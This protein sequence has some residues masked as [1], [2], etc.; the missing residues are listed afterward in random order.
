[1]CIGAIPDGR[2][3]SVSRSFLQMQAYTGETAIPPADRT[4]ERITL[5]MRI[6][7]W[8]WLLLL[9]YTRL[10]DGN[11][12][13]ILGAMALGTAGVVGVMAAIRSGFLGASWFAALDGLATLAL[14]A[15][16]W[17]AD[18]GEFIAGGYPMSW[19]FVAAYAWRMTGALGA[20]IAL[21]AWMGYLHVVM[22]FELTRTIGSIQFI[23]VAVIAGWT[24]DAIRQREALRLTAERERAAAETELS[25]QREAATRLEERTAIARELHDS[26][27]QTMKLISAAADD[28]SEVRYLARMQERNLRKTI[29]EYRSPHEDSLRARLLEARAE[30]EDKC[31]V[32]IEQVIRHD[33]E[34][35][36]RLFALVDAAK[37]AMTNAARHSGS[38]TIDLFAE[39]KP[40][41][42]QVNVRDRGNGFDPA[43]VDAGGITDSIVGR[44]REVGGYVDIDSRAGEGTDVSLFLPSR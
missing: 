23:V 40:G 28:P 25:A 12:T 5:M 41:G 32:H 7:G 16:G 19:L 20:S 36:P 38:P 27:L 13:I 22:G 15:A 18:A 37:E 30:V 33:A 17:A 6:L 26:V 1:M 21:T 3:P 24:F 4:L 29:N 11:S 14:L 10:D 8:V 42:V 34:M 9:S 31:R 43:H 35:T 2:E 44:M 39:V